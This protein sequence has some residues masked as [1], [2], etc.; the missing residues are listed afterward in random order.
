MTERLK[1]I[2]TTEVI[3]SFFTIVKTK[4]GDCVLNQTKART[5]WSGPPDVHKL[6]LR[7]RDTNG[8]RIDGRITAVEFQPGIELDHGKSL[9]HGSFA[10]GRIKN[11][12][13]LGSKGL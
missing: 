6:R 1:A 10:C 4:Q 8:R 9:L 5:A 13:V 2:R 7:T 12:C 11:H 3:K